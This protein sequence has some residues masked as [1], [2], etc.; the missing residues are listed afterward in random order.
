MC[1]T[2]T[3]RRLWNAECGLRTRNPQP[4]TR[5]PVGRETGR[6]AECG[7][8]TRN[9]QPAT[10][11]P[12]GREAGFT[13]AGVLVILTVI[14]VFVAYTVPRQWS[15]VMGR[16]RDQEAIFAMKQY[17]RAI[18]TWQQRHGGLPTSLDQLKQAR[19]PRL[20]RGTTGELLD[21]ITGKMDWQLVPPAAAGQPISG[22]QVLPGGSPFAPNLNLPKNDTSGTTST[23]GTAPTGQASAPKDY[24][25]P[26]V[27]VR[28]AKTGKAY[29]ALN[30]AENYEQWTY[31]IQNLTAEI[32]ARQ[33][34]IVTSK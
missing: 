9:P 28:P 7:L 31:T 34:A 24:V 15:E 17:A 33:A 6:N 3:C 32:N 4:A 8:R 26:F 11:N 23:S 5:N 16:E 14:M 29:V 12:V 30:G 1:H 10:R 25:G 21:P 22:P 18:L 19:T 27:G 13:L 2:R 20:V